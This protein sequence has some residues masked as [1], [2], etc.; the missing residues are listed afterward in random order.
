MSDKYLTS[1]L[2]IIFFCMSIVYYLLQVIMFENISFEDPIQGY[3]KLIVAFAKT[4][5]QNITIY[6][7]NIYDRFGIV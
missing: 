3:M 6:V 5:R 7:I 1:F 4:F 2:L